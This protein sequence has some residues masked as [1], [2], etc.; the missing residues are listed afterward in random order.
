MTRDLR[1][2]NGSKGQTEPMSRIRMSNMLHQSQHSKWRSVEFSSNRKQ[3]MAAR[4]SSF[5]PQ[6]EWDVDKKKS[7]WG[8]GGGKGGGGGGGGG[9]G[10]NAES[11]KIA[12]KVGLSFDILS[13][14]FSSTLLCNKV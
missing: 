14:S 3:K 10:T 13:F 2:I 11:A 5:R 4:N 8:D 1:I 12:D 7:E 6:S 9:G